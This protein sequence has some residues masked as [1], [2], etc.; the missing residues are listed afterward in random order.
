MVIVGALIGSGAANA[1]PAGEAGSRAPTWRLGAFAS[2][3]DQGY[4]DA[5]DE[6][7]AFPLIWFDGERLFFHAT[8]GGVRLFRNEIADSPL[9]EDDHAT[10]LRLGVSYAF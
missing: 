8:E 5:D 3:T 9:I 4:V 6:V 2:A 7:R 10:S 1:Q